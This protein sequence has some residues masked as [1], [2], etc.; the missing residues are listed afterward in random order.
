MKTITSKATVDQLLDPYLV[1]YRSQGV[2]AHAQLHNLKKST[3]GFWANVTTCLP[4]TG[5][6][7]IEK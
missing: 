5:T 1:V 2:E 4:I 7:F 6:L 3:C